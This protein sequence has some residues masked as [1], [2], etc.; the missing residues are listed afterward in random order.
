MAASEII[1]HVESSIRPVWQWPW[2][3]C[4][5]LPRHYR[6]HT[7]GPWWQRMFMASYL[8]VLTMKFNGKV[9]Q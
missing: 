8:S 2:F 4:K 1:V 7:I 6:E 3:L 5:R 9:V